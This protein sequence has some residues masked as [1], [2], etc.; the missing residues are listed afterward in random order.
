MQHELTAAATL[1]SAALSR[2]AATA[3]SERFDRMADLAASLATRVRFADLVARGDW[4]GAAAILKDVPGAFG[5]V[6]RVFLTDPGGTLRA[7]VPPLPGVRGKNFAER[8]WYRGVSQ[9]WRTT[10][11]PVYVRSAEPRRNVIAVAT[12]VRRR[13]TAAVAGILV[14]QLSL[15]S[16]FDWAHTLDLGPGADLAVV[17]PLGQAAYRSGV[18]VEAPI[19][20]YSAD[21]GVARLRADVAGP[22]VLADASGEETL[23][24]ADRARYGWGVVLRKPAALAFAVRDQQLALVQLAYALFALLALAF[25]WIALRI[26]AR[27]REQLAGARSAIARHAERLRILAEIDRAMVAEQPAESIAAAVIRPLRELLGVPRAIV[28]RFDLDQ[29]RVEWIAAAGRHRTHVGPGVSYS[30]ALMG[31][32]PSL[33]R[34]DTQLIDV[35]SFPESPETRAL[36][37][38]DVRYYKVVP[39]VAG[40]E[41]LG[42]ISFGGPTNAFPAEQV[43]IAQEV[44]TQLAIATMQARLLERVRGQ[45]AELEGR[46]LERTAALEAANKELEA[47]SYSVS[48]DLRAPLRGI[49]GYSRIL[50]EDYAAALDDEGRRVLGVI[51]GETLGMGRLIDD[52]LAFSRLGR[53]PMARESLDMQALARTVVEE[54]RNGSSAAVEIAALP[55]AEAD[56]RLLRQVWVNLVS[57]AFKYSGKRE[58]PVIRIEGKEEPE[59]AVYWV[60]D[61]GA[62]FDMR[63]VDKLFGVFQRLH[64]ED[65]YPG[66]GVGLAIVQRIVNRHGGRVW[67][68]AALG[69]G[70]CFYFS[71]PRGN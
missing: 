34:G 16:F 70:A 64:R 53:Q 1:Q 28:N 36:L 18:P 31:D 42:A 15:N 6:E 5:F 43:A 57:N 47:F 32:V 23:Y 56:P 35:R 61:N 40:G 19:A 66:T 22:V 48:H 69:E 68:E 30:L 55:A 62:G 8:A 25:T 14:L 45:A 3:L 51:R 44:A 20:D 29:G 67:A 17:D 50:E 4:D 2:L 49:E 38:S 46:V 52:L 21:P 58:A 24:A 54:L 71:L 39:M 33:R 12:P 11:S 65:E 26:A 59:R 13:D 27:R 63:Y 41:L 9:G 10:I 60:R 7:D 37:A